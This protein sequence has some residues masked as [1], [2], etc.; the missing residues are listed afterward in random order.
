M[1]PISALD[2]ET[3]VIVELICRDIWALHVSSLVNPI[4]PEPLEHEIRLRDGKPKENPATPNP[5][6]QQAKKT[7]VSSAENSDASTSDSELDDLVIAALMRE[8][9]E[10]ECSAY[11]EEDKKPRPMT[12]KAIKKIT[13]EHEFEMPI[14]TIAVLTV[15]A[16][17]LRVPLIYQ[18]LLQ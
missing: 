6:K 14:S 9:S 8:N 16:W 11:A 5:L 13:R 17:T 4:P 2:A 1:T 18:D 3:E 7:N 10:S 12:P 15:A